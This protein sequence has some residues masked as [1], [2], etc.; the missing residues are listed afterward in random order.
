M[1][2]TLFLFAFFFLSNVLFAQIKIGDIIISDSLA[3]EY[4]IDCYQHPETLQK[5]DYHNYIPA[6]TVYYDRDYDWAKIKAAEYNKYIDDN[7]IGGEIT[8]PVVLSDTTFYIKD[9]DT[10]GYDFNGHYDIHHGKTISQ[11]RN[12]ESYTYHTGDYV[13][14]RK[15]SAEDFTKWMIRIKK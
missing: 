14:P 9:G 3:K 13:V 5:D 4:F 8:V 6:N 15:P 12:A 1:K 11:H 2:T 10:T 7:S